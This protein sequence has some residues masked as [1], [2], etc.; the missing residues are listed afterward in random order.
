MFF[1]FEV[2]SDQFSRILGMYLFVMRLLKK[3]K[4]EEKNTHHYI[5]ILLIFLNTEKSILV[6]KIQYQS[7]SINPSHQQD[8]QKTFETTANLHFSILTATLVTRFGF[9]LSRPSASPITTWPKQPSPRGFPRTSLWEEEETRERQWQ[10]VDLNL[11][12][13]QKATPCFAHTCLCKVPSGDPGAVHTQTPPT[14]LESHWRRGERDGPASPQSG[15]RSWSP[16]T[17]EVR[18]T[19]ITPSKWIR[20]HNN[21]LWRKPK[22]CQSS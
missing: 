6:S 10:S 15:W 19:D 21:C 17:P 9:S 1:I 8:Q 22:C 14:A 2:F 7:R 13:N 4:K 20:H 11:C 18:N 12:V 5:V 3:K 16:Q